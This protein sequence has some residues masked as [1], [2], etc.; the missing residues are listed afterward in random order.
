MA[1]LAG[2]SYAL[3]LP[4]DV[5]LLPHRYPLRRGRVISYFWHR[6]R[7]TL[8]KLPRP[9]RRSSEDSYVRPEFQ[10]PDLYTHCQD[11]L[12]CK[13]TEDCNDELRPS[14]YHLYTCQWG[15]CYAGG[16]PSMCQDVPKH[17]MLMQVLDVAIFLKI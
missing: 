17:D 8:D 2:N 3:R 13:T 1:F 14:M 15:K 9:P 7:E 6:N 5:P 10:C 11:Q 4:T 16:F 12:S